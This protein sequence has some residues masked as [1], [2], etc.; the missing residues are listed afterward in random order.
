MDERNRG[1]MYACIDADINCGLAA[2]FT[3]PG[4]NE[5]KDDTKLGFPQFRK[6]Y[7][8]DM[9]IT[10]D[11]V[12]LLSSVT[13]IMILLSVLTSRYAE[14]D[15]RINLPT[16]LM[17]GVFALFVSIISMVLVFTAAMILIRD[18]EPKYSLVLMICLASLPAISFGFFQFPLWFE[19]FRSTYFS[20]Y[21]FRKSGIFL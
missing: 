3:L 18:N 17:F 10:S 14:D 16:K 9:F 1:R 13:A 15:F 11:S 6:K 21:L 20:K 5:S 2:A 8:F 19:I 4:G 12:S 7:W